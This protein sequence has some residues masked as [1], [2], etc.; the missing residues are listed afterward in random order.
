[1]QPGCLAI[2]NNLRHVDIVHRT[3][4]AIE[5]LRGAGERISFYSVAARAQVSRSTLYRSKD[6]RELVEAA[7]TDGAPLR[8][9]QYDAP[10]AR[11]AELEDE[12][13]RAL[14]ERNGLEQAIRGISPVYYAFMQ[15][16]DA[17]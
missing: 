2:T 7:R 1:M 3:V 12:L 14:L 16:T 8:Q 11:I 4:S 17:A 6:L 9:V 10:D 15:V 5:D 13:A